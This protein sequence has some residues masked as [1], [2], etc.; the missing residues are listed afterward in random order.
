MATNCI[1]RSVTLAAGESFTLPPGAELIS[2]TDINS[3]TSNCPLPSTLESLACYSFQIQENATPD[4][5]YDDV[6]V[7]GVKIEETTYNFSSSFGIP[8]PSPTAGAVPT[9][10][11]AALQTRLE[12]LGF[13]GLFTD[14]SGWSQ[15]FPIISGDIAV[16]LICF[17][18]A[19]SIGNSLSFVGLANSNAGP[20]A[21]N[22][23][24]NIPVLPSSTMLNDYFGGGGYPNFNTACTCNTGS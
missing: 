14:W 13:G 1:Y 10:V 24:V 7:S 11:I 4:G 16:T 17:K 9:V 18:T 8:N 6:T 5:P 3:I 23:F 22:I 21:P 2:A 12:E 20:G 15:E 19:P